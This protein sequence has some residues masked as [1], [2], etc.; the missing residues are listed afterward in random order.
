MDDIDV[1]FVV[2]KL[3][4]QILRSVFGLNKYQHRRLEA[5]H[6]AEHKDYACGSLLQFLQQ[7]STNRK[8]TPF[9]L[10]LHIQP[11]STLSDF[12]ALTVLVGG[13]RKGIRPV[14]NLS[15]GVLCS[16]LSRARCR[17]AYGPADATATHYLLFH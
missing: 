4:K 10:F 17:L 13:G 12:N 8:I 1:D 15:S 14:K 5:L 3:M 7:K 6:R 11:I 9:H 16:Y 2:G